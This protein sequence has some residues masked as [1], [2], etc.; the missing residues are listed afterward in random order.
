VQ[1]KENLKKEQKENLE[2]IKVKTKILVYLQCIYI[3]IKKKQN[4]KQ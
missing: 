4:E 2:K 1:Q 3:N